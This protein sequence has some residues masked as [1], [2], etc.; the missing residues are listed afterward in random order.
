MDVATP[1]PT[2]SAREDD[3]KGSSDNKNNSNRDAR[4][5]AAFASPGAATAGAAALPRLGGRLRFTCA[6]PRAPAGHPAAAATAAP[7]ARGAARRRGRRRAA[8]LAAAPRTCFALAAAR[9]GAQVGTPRVG[10]GVIPCPRPRSPSASTRLCRVRGACPCSSSP[11]SSLPA[12]PGAVGGCGPCAAGA[13]RHVHLPPCSSLRGTPRPGQRAAARPGTHFS[14]VTPTPSTPCPPPLR[15][16]QEEN[17]LHT[18]WNGRAPQS[19]TRQ[20]LRRCPLVCREVRAWSKSCFL[21]I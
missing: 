10:V 8:V 11:G 13:A 18:P 12:R 21:I 16:C 17:A 19:P 9:A 1:P 15:R 4:E 5:P 20:T 6:A 3:P 14:L 2:G 7:R